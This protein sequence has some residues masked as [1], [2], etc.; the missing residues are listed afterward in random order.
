MIII[1]KKRARREVVTTEIDMTPMIDCIFQLMIFFMLIMSISVVYGIA[2][3]FPSGAAR[4]DANRNDEKQVKPIVAWVGNDAY[5]EGHKIKYEGYVKLN[6][7]PIGLGLSTDPAKFRAEHARGMEYIYQQIRYL[8]NH[9]TEKY[10][11]TLN[12]LAPVNA[13]QGKIVEVI[14]QG[15]KAGLKGFVMNPPRY[16]E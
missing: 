15:K 14:D 1:P 6:G 16:D 7:E 5:D 3:R 2:I 10:D 4:N 13:Y 12:I 9:P 8:V 11:S